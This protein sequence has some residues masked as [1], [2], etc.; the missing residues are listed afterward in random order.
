MPYNSQADLV[1]LMAERYD[2]KFNV[3]LGGFT[4]DAS[5]VLRV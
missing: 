5:N 2:T 1:R 3:N 4:I